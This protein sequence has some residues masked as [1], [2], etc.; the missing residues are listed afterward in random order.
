MD[1]LQ[2]D[3]DDTS[4]EEL[5]YESGATGPKLPD[6]AIDVCEFAWEKIRKT[7]TPGYYPESLARDQLY[8]NYWAQI[9][10]FVFGLAKVR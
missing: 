9:W 6:W 4:P 8:I 1:E 10:R 7:E 3:H 5:L 2:S